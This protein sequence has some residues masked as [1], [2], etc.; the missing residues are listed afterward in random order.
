MKI[1]GGKDYYD[2]GMS[3]GQ[4]DDIM[5]IRNQPNDIKVTIPDNKLMH[6][7]RYKGNEISFEIIDVI[8][9]G[10]WINGVRF[11]LVD[12]PHTSKYAWRTSDLS[13]DYTYWI[14]D[15]FEW[16]YPLKVHQK[17]NKAFVAMTVPDLDPRIVTAIRITK[18]EVRRR[19][20]P[21]QWQIN[22]DGL[23]SIEFWKSVP[24]MEAFSKI[25][26][27]IANMPRSP[28]PMVE[29]SDEVRIHKH[30]FDKWSFRKHKDQKNIS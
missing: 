21:G 29:I 13:P 28:N 27:Y 8:I 1:Q 19:D 10:E 16:M 6:S 14:A 25:Y 15:G 4:D 30:G 3:F 17:H 7:L 23:K 18:S 12:K 9:A 11:N 20:E 24:P 26:A 5:F 2:H 22:T